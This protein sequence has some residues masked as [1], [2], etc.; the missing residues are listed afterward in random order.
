M[1]GHGSL[2]AFLLQLLV[3]VEYRFK[4]R[5]D[6]VALVYYAFALLYH[7]YRSHG[8]LIELLQYAS[9]LYRVV[10]DVGL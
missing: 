4:L 5:C 9:A 1:A 3:G 2:T 10:N 8:F 6:Y 7:T